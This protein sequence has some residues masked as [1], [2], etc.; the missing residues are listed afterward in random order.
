MKKWITL[1][2][3]QR[4]YEVTASAV[5]SAL[6]SGRLS[7]NKKHGRDRRVDGT[8]DIRMGGGGGNVK[9]DLLKAR[10]AK[11]QSDIALGE[12]KLSR[13]RREIINEFESIFF[14]AFSCSF[15]PMKSKLVQLQLSKDQI[16]ELNL[17]VD[18][19]LVSFKSELRKKVREYSD[20]AD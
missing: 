5:Y 15:A 17:I 3:Y 12:Q 11:L 8:T 18:G 14:E 6:N 1:T 4:R 19:C 7:D 13:T 16:K 10:L 9:D 20:E 2:E